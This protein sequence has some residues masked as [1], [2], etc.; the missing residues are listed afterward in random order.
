MHVVDSDFQTSNM[1]KILYLLPLLLFYLFHAHAGT[2]NSAHARIINITHTGTIDITRYGAQPDGVTK[3]T[4]AIQQAIDDCSK[5]GGGIVLV[6]AGNFYTGTIYL[7]DRVSLF[8]DKGAILSGSTDSTDYPANSPQT[9]RCLDT[10]G[11][12]GGPLKN[13]A[14]IYAEGQQD[15]S[16]LGEGTINGNGDYAGWQRGDNGHNRPKVIFLISCKKVTVKDITLRNSPFWMEDYLG[17]DGVEIEGI[18]VFNHANWNED[19]LDIDSKNV[20]VSNC[21]IDSDDDGICL[22]SYIRDQSCE[23]VTITNCV[24]S[25]NCNAI[26]LGTPGYGGFKNINVSNCTVGPCSIDLIRQL[27]NKYP[28]IT[29]APASVSGISL[30]CVDGGK[31]DGITINNITIRSTLTPIFMRLGNRPDRMLSDTGTYI[32]CLRNVIISNIISDGHSHRTSSITG[33]PGTYVENV[34]L[35]HIILDLDGGGTLAEKNVSSVKEKDGG[36]PTP[37]MFGQ[38]LPASVFYIRHVNGISIGDVWVNFSRDEARYPI[39]LDDVQF[40]SI[41]NIFIK[42]QTGKTRIIESGDIKTNLSE[43]IYLFDAKIK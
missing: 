23:N 41:K 26:K 35:H 25:T 24:V 29:A 5:A 19:G 30:E 16:I 15:I 9:I 39:V 37:E 14:L 3:C 17:C 34:Q 22:K 1:K 2:S 10:H 27:Q 7:K 33:Y 31:A 32:P 8:L 40:A 20:T 36:Y 21:I 6:P 4:R 38:S 18:H 42:D 13:Y 12:H 43:S 28:N 11:P